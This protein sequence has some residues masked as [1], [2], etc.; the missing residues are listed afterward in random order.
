MAFYFLTNGEGTFLSTFRRS[1]NA[2]FLFY[3]SAKTRNYPN[4]KM[5]EC[6]IVIIHSWHRQLCCCARSRTRWWWC[7]WIGSHA[8]TMPSYMQAHIFISKMAFARL[9]A[10]HKR[11][12]SFFPVCKW[13]TSHSMTVYMR[14]RTADILVMVVIW[15]RL[16]ANN[17]FGFEWMHGP[18][19]ECWRRKYCTEKKNTRLHSSSL[20]C[21][22]IARM[23]FR[24]WTDR[25]HIAF[26]VVSEFLG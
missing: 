6:A 10:I 17:L 11:I 19:A 13:I 22:A 24:K 14:Q 1:Q 4:G 3:L 25:I 15:L 16:L 18:A 7:C 26:N 12:N 23:Q 20:L 8:C 21:V 9:A 2:S 5:N